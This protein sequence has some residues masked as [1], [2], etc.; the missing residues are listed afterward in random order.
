MA[1]TTTLDYTYVVTG[2]YSDLYFGKMAI[3]EI[4]TFD[5]KAGRAVLLG[6]GDEKISFTSMNE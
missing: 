3:D 6:T 1:E 4:G 2:P 5:V